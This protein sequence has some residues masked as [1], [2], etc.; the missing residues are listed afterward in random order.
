LFH[1][2]LAIAFAIAY[3]SAEEWEGLHVNAGYVIGGLI[4]F[5][6][7]WGFVGTRHARFGDFV[8]PPADVRRY[9]GEALRLK[10]PR[11]LGHNPAGGAMVVALLVFLTLT[12]V[13]GIALHG[14]EDFA[15]PLAGLLRG[16]LAVDL[17][18][19]VHELAANVTVF[20]VV[21]HVAGVLFASLEHGE[22]LIRAMITGRK[23]EGLS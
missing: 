4:V 14:A 19:E 17:V 9:L 20:L 13:S 22:N 1:W 5:R 3:A 21:L 23:R 6:V 8:R 7:L 12:V 16:E 15:G 10:A 2:S 11:Y 18:E